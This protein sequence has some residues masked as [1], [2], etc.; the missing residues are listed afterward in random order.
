MGGRLVAVWSWLGIL[1]LA[2]LF[3]YPARSLLIPGAP[4]RYFP[5]DFMQFYFAGRLAAEGRMGEIHRKA[6][7]E[8]M[9]AELAAQGERNRLAPFNR[10]AFAAF[11]CIPLSWFPYRTALTLATLVNVCLIGFLVWKLPVWFSLPASFR[12]CLAGFLPFLHAVAVGQDTLLLTLLVA[13]AVRLVQKNRKLAAGVVLAFC[14]VKPHLIWAT[15]FAFLA[16]TSRRALGSYLGTGLVLVAVS[17]LCVGPHGTR[18][19]LDLL[20]GPTTDYY[21]SRMPNLRGF[22][23]HFGWAAAGIAAVLC[24]LCFGVILRQASFPEQFAASIVTSLLINPHTYLSDLSLLAIAAA[25]TPIWAVRLGLLL[26]WP[27]FYTP[28]D[29]LPWVWLMLAFLVTVALAPS[30]ERWRGNRQAAG[31]SMPSP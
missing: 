17:W 21:P 16:R 13:V 15:P 9:T 10:P 1:G 19:W 25:L 6:T 29:W 3:L 8:P 2:A 28:P 12:V 18:E 27:Y 26:P 4:K 14:A 23:Y 5:P 7:Y 31:A 22:G 24:L 11:F 20:Q 30:Y